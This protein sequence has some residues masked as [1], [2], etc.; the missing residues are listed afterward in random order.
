MRATTTLSLGFSLS[1]ALSFATTGC[2][3]STP[4]AVATT[5]DSGTPATTDS[6]TT[7]TDGGAATG[8]LTLDTC[9]TNIAATAPEFFKRFFRCV[10]ITTT[11]T[12]VVISTNA[13]PPHRSYYY[14]SGHANYEDF[15]TTRGATY[16]PAP[17]RLAMKAMAFTVPIAPV[18][19]NLTITSAMVDGT[20]GSNTNEYPMGAAGVALDSVVLYNP[21]ARPGD[22]IEAEKYTF[23]VYNAHP[24]PD[25]VYHYHTTSKGPLEVLKKLGFVT[26]TEPG[27]AAIELYGIMC[28]GTPVLGCKELDATSPTGTLDAQ[29]GHAHDLK[30]G[31]GTVLLAG[32]YHTHICTATGRKF[33]PEIQYYSSCTR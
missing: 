9:G 18:S 11:T 33:T 28:D 10:T 2:G 16:R 12:S 15:D 27:G 3:T 19:R 25:S 13:L 29:G 5:T 20:V 30:S 7:T 4:A 24:S 17:N 31:D 23:D 8:E 22:D 1:L 6:G 14:G 32:R 21:L 26:T